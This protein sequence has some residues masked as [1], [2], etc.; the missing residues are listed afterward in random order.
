MA[1]NEENIKPN[2]VKNDTRGYG[3]NYA[4]LSDIALQGYEIPKMK[5]GTENGKEYV[6]FKDGDEWLRG[7]E[8]VIPQSKGMNE[9]QLY[10]SAL[11]YARRYTV[12]MADCLATDDDIQV[13]KE[14]LFDI[15]NQ[16]DINAL[17]KQFRELY[18]VEE[19]A[20]ILNQKKILSPEEMDFEAL[21]KYVEYAKANKQTPT[22]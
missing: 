20:K 1:K 10:G 22:R 15:P 5:T 17:A 7:A 21:K 8:I 14:V 12:L 3:Y 6:F 2:I 19:Q 13:E 11:T 16:E 18:T 9:A 4:S